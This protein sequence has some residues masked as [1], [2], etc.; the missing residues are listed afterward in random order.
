M[1]VYG[2]DISKDAIA[3][4][5]LETAFGKFE[6][7][8][9]HEL[10]L[11]GDPSEDPVQAAGSLLNQVGASPDRLIVSI[12]PELT[13]YRN[14]QLATRDKKAIRS[15]LEF[16]LEDDLPFESGDLHY[17]SSIVE[18]GPQGSVVHVGAVRKDNLLK[19]LENLTASG[20]DPDVVTTEAW[21]F[22]SLF[23][24]LP[25]LPGSGETYLLV[26]LERHRTTFYIHHKNR[27]VL[28]RE[29]PFGLRVMESKLQSELSAGAEEAKNWLRD[30]GVSGIDQQVSG[31][32]ADLLENLLPE[33]KQTEL[34]SRAQTKAPIDQVYVTGEGALMPGLLTWLEEAT[35]RPCI[36]FRPLS[37]LSPA[38]VT[39]S[40]L[41]EVRFARALAL[42]MTPIPLDKLPPLNLRKGDFAKASASGDSP[43]ELLKKPLPYIATTA[44]VF[45]ATKGIEYS[46]FKGKLTETEESAKR[47]V[48][49]YYGGISDSAA[50][51]Y[52][53]DPEKLKKTI[54][55][56]VAKERELS[57][58]LSGNPNSP[59]EFLR[60][61]SQK[62]AKDVVVDLVSFDA[63][64]DF[65]DRYAENR[66]MKT[67]LTFVVSNPQAIQKLVDLVE[68]GF[69]LKKGNSEEFTKEG[70][71]VYRVI[72]SGVM[73]GGK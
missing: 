21:A 27:P 57:K 39:Y 28:Y 65:T 30:I 63:G 6:I 13:T 31:A 56:E 7:R 71:K 44:L 18:S 5:E 1:R 4:V 42:A 11:T 10:A 58:L 38:S 59:L 17:D 49:A 2:L 73:G 51:T 50:R 62:I 61:L 8:Q 46:Y 43:L 68:K 35:Q 55:S 34:A 23:S 40:D 32:I 69:G 16:E 19:H 22:R 36:L 66:P 53:A 52:L 37:S 20:I 26:G 24:R 15:A 12:P 14:L 3:C 33:L 72:F 48:K 47:A 54:H 70:K 45:L 60:S 67:S 25:K 64:S 41:S 9:T 29:I